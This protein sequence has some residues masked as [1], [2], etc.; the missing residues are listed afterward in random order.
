MPRYE[1]Q[2][3]NTVDVIDWAINDGP[4]AQN[5]S[6]AAGLAAAI[7]NF[8]GVH[9]GHQKVVAAAT[10]AGQRNNL[11]SVVITFDPHPR[12][13]FAGTTRRFISRIGRK[14]TDC[15]LIYLVRANRRRLSMCALMM[16]CARPMRA[17][18]LAMF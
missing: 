3:E 15:Y 8:D 11:T 14:K 13:F 12:E 6:N 4:L 1:N 5:C 16:R 7:G 10:E 2:Q 9:R 18:L 17:I